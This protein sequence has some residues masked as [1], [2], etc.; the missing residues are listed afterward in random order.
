MTEIIIIS[1][2]PIT[3]VPVKMQMI[4]P[5]TASTAEMTTVNIREARRLS[6]SSEFRLKSTSNAPRCID[7]DSLDV[8]IPAIA[9]RMLI[10]GVTRT[11]RPGIKSRT[12]F[13]DPK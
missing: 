3:S 6:P 2:T 11:I 4:F 5:N 12:S 9:P 7:E 13:T 1:A 8:K 10:E